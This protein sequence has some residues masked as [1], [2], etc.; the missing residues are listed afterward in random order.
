[1]RT[2]DVGSYGT[3]QETNA[4]GSSADSKQLTRLYKG[5]K[6]K[7][8]SLTAD[9]DSE[10]KMKVDFDALMC[11]TD[12]GRL[13]DS[14]P[15]DRY[16]AHRMFENIGN[17]PLERKTAGIAPNT[18]KPFF[19]Y[20]GTITAFGSNIAQVTKFDLSG[21]NNITQ[22]LVV[23]GS[24][25]VESRNTAGQSLEQIPF[26][27]SRNPALAIEG[28]VEYKL[29][30]EILPTDPLLWHEFRTARS[31][32][33]NEPI[34]LHLVKDG[35]GSD[36]EEVYVVID[37]YIITEAPMQIPEDKGVIKQELQILPR[38]VKILAYDAL[39]HC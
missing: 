33:Y 32:G 37:D 22:H 24:P 36:R 25:A 2:R 34:T 5:C 27:G 21:E 6:V 12:T 28:K 3:D 39:L 17:G 15:G 16:T 18:E 38:H 4:P 35:A 26:A 11:Y 30:M 14:T 8:W 1:M 7:S 29:S 13:E 9:A 19:F 23:R 10:V 20:N 31:K